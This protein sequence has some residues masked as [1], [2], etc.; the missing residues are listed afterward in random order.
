MYLQSPKYI[1]AYKQLNL[2]KIEEIKAMNEYRGY[3]Q[4][5]HAAGSNIN[6]L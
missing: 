1:Y 3:Q 2:T 6:P 4:K 5:E